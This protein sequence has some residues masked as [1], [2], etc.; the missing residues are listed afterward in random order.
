MLKNQA[1]TETATEDGYSTDDEIAYID[2]LGTCLFLNPETRLHKLRAKAL[3]AALKRIAAEEK[4]TA[5]ARARGLIQTQ[6]LRTKAGWLRAYIDAS[7]LRKQW[8]SIDR[9][10]VLHYA[11]ELLEEQLRRPGAPIQEG[12]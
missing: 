11:T 4:H 8:G 9:E 12:R 5:W 10:E 6:S 1:F 7:A 2:E 3:R